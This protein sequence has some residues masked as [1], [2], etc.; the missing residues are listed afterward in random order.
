M[1]F[2][3]IETPLTESSQL[4]ALPVILYILKDNESIKSLCSNSQL[5][6][7][8]LLGS[9][10]ISKTNFQA[11]V[12][13]MMTFIMLHLLGNCNSEIKKEAYEGRN[14]DEM[15]E[16]G[17]EYPQSYD[18]DAKGTLDEVFPQNTNSYMMSQNDSFNN[19]EPSNA[20]QE[21][22]MDSSNLIETPVEVS[23][24]PVSNSP[25]PS[26]F[27]DNFQNFETF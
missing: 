1:S 8:L 26:G 22:V 16:N 3:F 7:G 20:P 15:E 12:Y 9:V 24:E 19:V 25:E 6:M 11:S 27:D 23:A 5:N 21:N 10:F 14:Q 18:Y 17:S 2:S 13:L 4:I